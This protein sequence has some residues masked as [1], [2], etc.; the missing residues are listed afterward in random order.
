[1]LHTPPPPPSL[2]LCTVS[3]CCCGLTGFSPA[4]HL[5]VTGNAC[6]RRYYET[7]LKCRKL[8]EAGSQQLLLD[9]QA[10]R[11]LLLE[12]PASGALALPWPSM[13]EKI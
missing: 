4:K 13:L 11:G 7:V 9:T 12:F 2:H 10:I 1:M 6:L 3:S 5:G 8:T